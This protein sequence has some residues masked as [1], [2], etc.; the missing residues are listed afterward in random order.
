M[1]VTEKVKDVI[2][3]II[4]IFEE[5]DLTELDIIQVCF[6]VISATYECIMN[7]SNDEEKKQIILHYSSTSAKIFN[8]LFNNLVE[9][10]VYKTGL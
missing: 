1:T 10:E 8:M 6:S 3:K 9:K 7:R 5:N 2:K 4:D